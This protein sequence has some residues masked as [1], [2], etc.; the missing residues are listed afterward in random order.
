MTSPANL[1]Q[2][3]PAFEQL[4]RAYNVDA[5]DLARHL[6]ETAAD[7]GTTTPAGQVTV[8]EVVPLA[9]QALTAGTVRTYRSYWRRLRDGIRL[10]ASTTDDELAA[11][12]KDLS[13]VNADKRDGLAIPSLADITRDDDGQPVIV[14]GYADRP[15]VSIRASEIAVMFKWIG[16]HAIAEGAA[17]DR[18]RQMQDKPPLRRSGKNA[19]ENFVNAV[20]ALYRLA[21]VDELIPAD[22]APAAP[23]A[24]PRRDRKDQRRP[25]TDHE[26]DD[27]WLTVTTTGHDPQLDELIFRLQL[28]TG[29]RQEGCINLRLR[30]LDTDRQSLWLDQKGDKRVEMP[31]TADL[32]ADLQAFASQRGATN[33]EDHVL[34]Q[35]LRHRRTGEPNPPLT[36]RRFD[37]LYDRIRGQHAWARKEGLSSHWLRHHVAAVFEA[38]GGTPCKVRVLDHEISG[39]TETY[40]RAR[41]EHLAWALATATGKPHPLAQRPPWLAT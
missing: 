16:C 38:V 41:F 18:R 31:V 3:L 32:L 26:L 6:L 27:I 7:N 9:E 20:N 2:A 11:Y 17:L 12:L 5:T 33:P 14:D 21:A 34:R 23:I 37:S 15:L 24:R 8:A 35:R 1:S 30:D 40:G 25:L 10:P 36:S 28:E 19:Q 4:L 39:P 29:A 22:C 13:A